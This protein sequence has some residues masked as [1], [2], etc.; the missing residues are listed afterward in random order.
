MVATGAVDQRFVVLWDVSDPR[1]P[2]RLRELVL[3]DE[4]PPSLD[5]NVVHPYWSMDGRMVAVV[6]YELKTVTVFDVGSGREIWSSHRVGRV[7]QV[8]FSPD[9]ETLAVVS[10][11][12]VA[13]SSI[14]TLWEIG[15]WDE[16]R[17]LVLPGSGGLGVEF[18]RGG[19]VFVTTSEVAGRDGFGGADGS[20][21]A[22]LW[23]AATL[24]PI[25]EPLLLGATGRAGY[26]DRDARGERAVI[27]S[28]GG[29]ALVWDLDV[30]HWEDMACSIAGRNLTRAEWA[31]YLPGEPYH[32][33]CRQ[34]PAG[35]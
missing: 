7:G 28:G 20:S 11:D 25:G 17:S 3:E 4:Q 35:K 14:L 1:E 21:G 29:M 13:A 9:S 15:A 16:P 6:D 31:Q 34:W 30:S 5:G 2:V 8:A 23:D 18:L 26:V 10:Q 32:A 22:Q 19:E 12:D 27:G 33:T 24:E